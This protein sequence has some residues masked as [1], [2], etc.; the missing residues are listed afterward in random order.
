[1]IEKWK[2][3]Y[4]GKYEISN[5]GNV[6]NV[7]S[8]YLLKVHNDP[9]RY[10]ML[11]ASN[12]KHSKKYCMVHR[13][14]ARKFLGRHSKSKCFVNHKDL[15]KS[16]NCVSNLEWVTRS[17]NI[18]HA[19]ANGAPVGRSKITRMQADWIRNT[20]KTS[21]LWPIARLAELFGLTKM[22][23]YGIVWGK[24]WINKI[25]VRKNNKWVS[26]IL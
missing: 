21:N 18:R 16:N 6:R 3:F 14:V 9:N 8:G 24:S 4:G 15:N 2:P 13:V 22:A 11:Y 1:M 19:I 20:F 10:V 23:I 26:V 7:S 25:W 12:R 5:Q 17:Q